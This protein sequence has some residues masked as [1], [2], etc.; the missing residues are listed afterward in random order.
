LRNVQ[1]EKKLEKPWEAKS[2]KILR[3]IKEV[4]REAFSV[5][6]LFIHFYKFKIFE[7]GR[8]FQTL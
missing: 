6:E 7:K 2:L 1:G 4:I 8:V 5:K 3:R